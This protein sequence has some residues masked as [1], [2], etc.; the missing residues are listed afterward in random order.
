MGADM[1]ARSKKCGCRRLAL[2]FLLPAA[3]VPGLKFAS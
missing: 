2:S 1:S 3:N